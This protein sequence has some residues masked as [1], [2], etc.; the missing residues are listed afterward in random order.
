MGGR[1]Q[2]QKR[3]RQKAVTRTYRSVRTR[4][5][6]PTPQIVLPSPDADTTTSA[7]NPSRLDR[8]DP[9][10]WTAAQYVRELA[11]LGIE[12][13]R[14]VDRK[15]LAK[16]YQSNV[17][18]LQERN[19]VL[20][21]SQLDQATLVSITAAEHPTEGRGLA[22]CAA[23]SAGPDCRRSQV[24]PQQLT[25]PAAAADYAPCS[26]T[27]AITATSV[28]NVRAHPPFPD[29]NN[30]AASALEQLKEVQSQVTKLTSL[31]QTGSDNTAIRCNIATTT[32]DY[33]G[34]T[35]SQ[36][37]DGNITTAA[38]PT[39]INAVPFPGQSGQ[40][41][42]AMSSL[43]R[44]EIVSPSLRKAIIEGKHVN[45][46][47]LCIN[48]YEFGEVRSVE[49]GEL[50]LRLKKND[51]R[52][53]R[54]LN[55]DQF[56]QAFGKYKRIM[57]EVFPSRRAE[58]DLYQKDIEDLYV[59]FPDSNTAYEYH[60]A[61]S[62]NCA[63][64][65]QYGIKVDWSV[66]DH[67]LYAKVTAGRKVRSCNLCGSI[68]HGTGFCALNLDS[69]GARVMPR[70]PR[71][72]A[73][74]SG[75][76]SNDSARDS[77]GRQ[78]YFHDSQEICNNFNR[79]MGCTRSSCNYLHACSQCFEAHS[80]SACRAPSKVAR[81]RIPPNKNDKPAAHTQISSTQH[82]TP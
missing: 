17:N 10:N 80:A 15:V 45:L 28:N 29:N 59:S 76:R 69:Y 55:M 58:L 5:T 14:G 57:C 65:L 6:S 77:A 20:P 11:K 52:M 44:R 37:M 71:N 8:T 60:K 24:A 1:G 82:P 66:I 63:S 4:T 51:P 81:S 53:E 38:Q 75:F 19:S 78:R 2:G 27:T 21:E 31:F 25:E 68:E 3:K 18:N 33:R 39:A 64:H 56:V 54:S 72:A 16:F 23:T 12:A 70:A 22:N 73:S 74:A 79:Q 42:V 67:T 49:V 47:M 32:E 34:Y 9:A 46:N 50:S 41:G 13:P 48:N 26:P 61:F 30:M 7:N 43:P 36:V 35:L 40:F 62:A